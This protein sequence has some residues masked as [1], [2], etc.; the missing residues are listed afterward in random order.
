VEKLQ[1]L[2]HFFPRDELRGMYKYALNFCIRRIN[3]GESAYLE[4][5]FQVYQHMLAADL[6]SVNGYL[7]HT[8]VKNIATSAIR[9]GEFEWAGTFIDAAR[10]QVAAPYAQNVYT[11]CLALLYAGSGRER[12]AIRLLQEV[13]FTDVYYALSARNLLLQIYFDQ[14]DWDALAYQV[15]AYQW[16]LRRNS[17]ISRRNRNLHLQFAKFFKRLVRLAEKSSIQSNRSLQQGCDALREELS[18]Q[19]EIAN[20]SWLLERLNR[21]APTA[22]D[23]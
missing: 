21:L 17:T 15:K 12:E 11:Y 1:E 23:S 18:A 3:A 10:T 8:D 14:Q 5:S 20:R 6:L 13:Q 7:S 4:E 16:F 2:G 22:E 19:E 9:M